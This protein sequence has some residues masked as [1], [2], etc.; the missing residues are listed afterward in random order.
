[1]P[2]IVVPE[3]FDLVLDGRVILKHRKDDPCL[4]VGVGH[5]RMDMYRGNFDIEDYVVER[6]PLRHA[7][8]D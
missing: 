5:A 8:V 4:F 3:G 6:V 2:V 1:M 7:K